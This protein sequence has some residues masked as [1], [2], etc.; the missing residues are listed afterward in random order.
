MAHL[1]TARRVD[2]I[3]ESPSIAAAA[4]ARAL[5]AEGHDVLD[6]TVGEPDFDTPEHV[7]AAAIAAIRRGETKYTS[8]SGTPAL[9]EAIIDRL[10]RRTGI[11]Y[12]HAQV[13][14]GGGAKQIIYLAFSATLD[15]GDEVIV[16]APYWVSYPDMVLANDGTPVI[17][18]CPEADGF[19]LTPDSLAAAI[20]PR[21]RWVV[22]NMPGNPTGA[23]YSPA[24]LRGLADVLLAHPHVAVLTDE[25]YDEIWFDDGAVT[26]IVAVEPALADRVL[27]VN[28]VSKTYAMT[29]WRLGYAAGP[30]PLVA[31]INK[32]QGQTSSCPSSISQAAAVAA[33]SGDQSPV[34][35][36]VAVYRRRR[37]L[38]VDRLNAIPGISV[39]PP[40]GAFYLFPSC[41]GLI[42]RTIPAGT[43]LTGDADVVRYLLDAAKVA[44]VHGGAY[45]L[46]PYFRL[47]FATSEQVL[48]RAC[49]R[50]AG[51]VADLRSTP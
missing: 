24:Q 35:E 34:R 15:E 12:E 38:A 42:G 50:I 49:E 44:S 25:I 32:L 51:A 10:K 47:S 22:L 36:M 8:V 13:T 33:L 27:V 40:S 20:T 30:A 1:H 14:V 45:G 9:R 31:A 21:T 46:S 48:E 2:R 4:R 39:T 7:K 23:S 11:G 16:P 6:L 43:V 29:G 3:R 41:A 18:E 26:S 28:G 5:V 17:V 19:L 37:D